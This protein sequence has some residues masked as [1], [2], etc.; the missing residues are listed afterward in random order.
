MAISG[1]EISSPS[2]GVTALKIE[3]LG[4]WNNSCTRLI[5]NTTLKYWFLDGTVSESA[6]FLVDI[7]LE[8]LELLIK[9]ELQEA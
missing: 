1:E 3:A 5:L 6:V 7:A 2:C 9:N 8:E 4:R